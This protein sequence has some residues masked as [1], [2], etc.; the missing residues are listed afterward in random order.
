MQPDGGQR[1][2]ENSIVERQEVLWDVGV[3]VH[4][5]GIAMEREGSL[6][7]FPGQIEEMGRWARCVLLMGDLG[8]RDDLRTDE[9]KGRG[10][11]W[12]VTIYEG[13]H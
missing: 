12:I 7:S 9:P 10:R 5:G 4:V 8:N 6:P 11:S 13:T 3:R 1:S 2:R